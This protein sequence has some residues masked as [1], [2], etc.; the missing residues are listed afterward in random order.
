MT[1]ELEKYKSE[2][3]DLILQIHEIDLRGC[4]VDEERLEEGMKAGICPIDIAIEF[5]P[6]NYHEDEE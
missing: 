6:N 2:C 5:D 1:K 3:E 4:I